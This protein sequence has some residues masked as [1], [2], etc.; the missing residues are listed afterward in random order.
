[1][2]CPV[3]VYLKNEI[4]DSVDIKG[5]PHVLDTVWFV[6]C[7]TLKLLIALEF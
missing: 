7:F 5:H 2:M 6:E 1:M 4:K 3:L